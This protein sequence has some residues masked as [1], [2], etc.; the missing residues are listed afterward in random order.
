MPEGA[1]HSAH[2]AGG[3]TAAAVDVLAAI[4]ADALVVAGSGAV[5]S[6]G[7][8]VPV[9]RLQALHVPGAGS[10]TDAGRHH[11]CCPPRHDSCCAGTEACASVTSAFLQVLAT[12]QRVES[13]RLD[14]PRNVLQVR[15]AAGRRRLTMRQAG[16][17]GCMRSHRRCAARLCVPR[18]L[19]LLLLLI[20][21]TCS[22]P[23]ILS[24]NTR[25]TK[26]V[27]LSTGTHRVA[28][29]L[30]RHSLTDGEG[31][32]YSTNLDR[33]RYGS[34]NNYL[35]TGALRCASLLLHRCAAH[36]ACAASPSPLAEPSPPPAR[37]APPACSDAVQ[38][39]GAG[40]VPLSGG[41]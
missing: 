14:C 30:R 25:R 3:S 1:R 32:H 6:S 37:S 33:N 35:F 38:S 15:G 29:E 5:G 18:P 28:D 8:A 16:L 20:P 9:Q 12:I 11:S 17:A 2:C 22:A 21:R 4:R 36:A 23:Q 26:V 31:G 40:A 41:H 7:Q 39:G 19:R 10:S 34:D 24:T 27:E 13:S